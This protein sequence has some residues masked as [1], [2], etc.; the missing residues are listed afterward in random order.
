[1]GLSE[2]QLLSTMDGHP[3]NDFKIDPSNLFQ[4]ECEQMTQP[5]IAIIPSRGGSQRIPLKSLEKVGGRSLLQRTIETARDSK[6]F[7]RII[8]STDSEKIASEGQKFGAEVPRLR[9][10]ASDNLTPVSLATIHTLEQLLEVDSQFLNATVYQL[11]PNC[12]FLSL[13]TLNKAF[14]KFQRDSTNSLL[15]AVKADPIHWFAFEID[16]YGNYKRIIEGVK[17]NMRTQ[18]YPTMYVPSGAVWVASTSYLLENR[19]FYGKN[20]KFFEV[21]FIDGFDIDTKEQLEFARTLAEK[22]LS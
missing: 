10:T 16:E 14:S 13:K 5:I 17:D 3:F 11:M 20:F 6:L 18:D 2:V 12:P 9:T 19:N 4:F 22:S 8:V 1:M 15:S 7:D 21:P